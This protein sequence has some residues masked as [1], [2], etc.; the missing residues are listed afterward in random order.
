VSD[1]QPIK[2]APK[3]GTKVLLIFGNEVDDEP[4]AALAMWDAND[5]WLDSFSGR[6][7]TDGF[8]TDPTHWM[9]L[10]PPPLKSA[11]ADNQLTTSTG[12]QV[13]ESCS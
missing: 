13:D 2:T 12:D 3:D 5:G 4:S 11:L 10:P 6:S 1:W 7:V 9:P 8:F